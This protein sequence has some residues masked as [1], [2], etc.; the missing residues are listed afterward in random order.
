MYELRNYN[1]ST[2]ITFEDGH[3]E[4]EILDDK[5]ISR[6]RALERACRQL[7]R[8][9]GNAPPAAFPIG[10]FDRADGHFIHCSEV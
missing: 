9:L 4:F 10:I 8:I 5:P 3:V 2:K 1:P 6:H 7:R